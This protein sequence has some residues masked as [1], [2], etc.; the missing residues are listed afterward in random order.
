VPFEQRRAHA[1]RDLVGA[2]GHDGD[3]GRRA[4][5]LAQQPLVRD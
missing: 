5:R 2:D 3:H 1:D 4:V